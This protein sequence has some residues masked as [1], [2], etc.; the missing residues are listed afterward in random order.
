MDNRSFTM[1]TLVNGGR[2]ADADGR[3][4][5]ARG[6]RG[7]EREWQAPRAALAPSSGFDDFG[8]FGSSGGSGGFGRSGGAP[9]KRGGRR[10]LNAA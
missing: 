8:D 1:V 10:S 2:R 9:R 6:G 3:A 5:Q 7:R 4:G